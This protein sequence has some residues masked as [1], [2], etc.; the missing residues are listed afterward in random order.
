MIKGLIFDF[1]G[2]I[3]DTELP[4]Y[5]TWQQVFLEY[6]LSLPIEEWA[7]ALGASY[8]AF[9]PALYLMQQTGQKLDY[10]EL[11][12]VH[13]EMSLEIIN[14]SPA[15]P[16]VNQIILRARQLGLSL[17]IASS[18]P[19]DWVLTHLE[20]LGLTLKFDCILTADDVERVKPAPDLFLLAL[21]RLKLQPD[22]AIVFEDSPNGI[23]AGNAAGIFTIGVPNAIS[24]LLDTNHASLRIS[25]LDAI[26]LDDMIAAAN[27]GQS[28][29]KY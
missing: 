29:T 20:R 25:S 21:S 7:K 17:A 12:R 10:A 6:G 22:E 26:T 23:T 27:T 15:L 1:D 8:A 16:G 24:S 9:D 18:S 3:L 4:E 14:Q 19:S 11:H 28:A 2:L 13:N 5:D